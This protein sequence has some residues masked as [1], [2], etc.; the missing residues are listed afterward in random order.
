MMHLK[1]SKQN[2]LDNFKKATDWEEISKRISYKVVNKKVL[3]T[4]DNPDDICYKEFFDLIRIPVISEV[5][6]DRKKLL[7]HTVTKSDLE[8][9]NKTYEEI[10]SIAEYN[11]SNADNRRIRTLKEDAMAHEVM[12]PIMQPMAQ[13]VLGNKDANAFI[14]DSEEEHDNILMVSN[15]YNMYGASYI[16]DKDTLETLY[17][18]LNSNFYIVP[19]SVHQLMCISSSYLH[20]SKPSNEVEDDLLDMLFEINSKAKNT[21]DIL[22]YQIYEYFGDDGGFLFPIKKRL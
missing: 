18:R 10:M 13:G 12:A 6:N 19:L 21:D 1:E 4:I 3:K 11:T 22:T 7:S 5:S 2:N 14:M 16:M 20:A 9:F 17:E 8:T 15:K